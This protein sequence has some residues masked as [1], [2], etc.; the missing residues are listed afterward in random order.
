MFEQQV[1]MKAG[2]RVQVRWQASQRQRRFVMVTALVV[3]TA[4]YLQWHH[5]IAMPGHADA[6]QS[7]PRSAPP[8][9]LPHY[10][11]SIDAKVV[12]GIADN[13]S[14]L[15]YNPE[16]KTLFAV[17]NRPPQIAELSTDGRLLR[18]APLLGADDTEGIAHI[19]GDWFAI[20][21]ERSNR[22]HWVQFGKGVTELSLEN[23]PY[24]Q[25]GDIHIKNFALEG[26]GWDAKRQQLLA[27]TEKWPMQ[28]LVIDAPLSKLKP[29]R[30][31]MKVSTWEVPAV[32]N[33]P[34]TDLAAIEVDPRSGNLLL[35]GEEASVLYEYSRAGDLLSVMPLW[36]DMAGLADRVPQPEGLA[37]DNS[38]HIY[39]VSEPNLFYKFERK[40]G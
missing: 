24:I 14:G 26:L 39:I 1:V 16:T 6:L 3:L 31:D 20:A 36:A 9:N 22:I 10:Q 37:V 11:A 5:V 8:A 30:V 23:S 34:S 19:Q 35:L 38:G 33:M 4:L 15:A 21:D 32:E 12:N 17:T 7:A 2:S 13:L 27:V 29:G 28:V 40:R 18:L 25:L